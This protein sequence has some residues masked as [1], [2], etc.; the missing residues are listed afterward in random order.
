ML[1]ERDVELTAIRGALDEAA[2]GHGR[3]LVF[4]GE[5]GIGKSALLA[6][7]ATTATGLV[8]RMRGAQS[9]R[10]LP[11]AGLHDLLAPV[12]DAVTELPRPQRKALLGALAIEPV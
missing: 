12:I 3:T 11:F 5:P 6:S 9:E 2:R 4:C 7:A 8:L 10:E 1:V